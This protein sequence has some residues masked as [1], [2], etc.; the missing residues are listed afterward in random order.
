LSPGTLEI[1]TK[2]PLAGLS[3]DQRQ[4]TTSPTTTSRCTTL[5][6]FLSN[7]V[8]KPIEKSDYLRRR[9]FMTAP[10]A[11]TIIPYQTNDL[12]CLKR[13]VVAIQEHERVNVPELKTGKEIGASYADY[14][15]KNIADNNGN[16]LLAWHAGEPIGLICSWIDQDNDQLLQD[17]FRDHAYISDIYVTAEWRGK[18][19]AQ[20]LIKFIEKRMYDKGCRRIRVCSKATNILAMSFYEAEGYRAYEVIFSKKLTP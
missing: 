14:L 6:R 17:G 2:A 7:L 15:L 12:V 20:E 1:D 13:F 19:V 9:N 4:T 10:S 16:I 5:Q 11:V 3:Y 18:G 8:F